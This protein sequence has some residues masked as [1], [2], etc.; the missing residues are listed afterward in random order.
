[1]CQRAEL[2][3]LNYRFPES[4]FPISQVT[5]PFKKPVIFPSTALFQEPSPSAVITWP[6]GNGGREGN[7]WGQAVCSSPQPGLCASLKL[8]LRPVS[9]GQVVIAVGRGGIQLTQELP[10]SLPSTCSTPACSKLPYLLPRDQAPS[11]PSWIPW[12]LELVSHPPSL[13]P[14][15][16]RLGSV[17]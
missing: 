10:P 13:F 11:V 15:S 5:L 1:M 4:P 6:L 17:V 2:L 7:P 9:Q 16:P 3:P 8:L 12:P 14:A